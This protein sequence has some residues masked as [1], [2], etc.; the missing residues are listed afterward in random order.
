MMISICENFITCS[1][2][3]YIVCK[4]IE[5]A[6]TYGVFLLF[7]NYIGGVEMALTLH[8]GDLNKLARDT[9]QDSINFMVGGQKIIT[10]ESTGDIYVKR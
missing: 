2:L 7:K 10:L 3:N 5:E 8:N 1:F 4:R 6:F 9:S